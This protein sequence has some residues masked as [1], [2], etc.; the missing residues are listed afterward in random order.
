MA[1]Y[2]W[3]KEAALEYAKKNKINIVGL[4]N[5]KIKDKIKSWLIDNNHN[6]WTCECDHPIQQDDKFCPFCGMDTS[7]DETGG[8]GKFKSEVKEQPTLKAEPEE[9][10][11]EEV[12]EEEIEEEE[13]E[14]VDEEP[15]KT[16]YQKRVEQ[17]KADKKKVEENFDEIRAEAESRTTEIKNVLAKSNEGYWEI[18]FHLHEIVSK[19]GHKTLNYPTFKEYLDKEFG[20]ARR[21]AYN[22]MEISQKVT[23]EMARKVGSIF[24][25]ATACKVKDEK[26]RN[27]LLLDA[28]PKSNKVKPKVNVNNISET[29]TDLRVKIGEIDKPRPAEQKKSKYR[30]FIGAQTKKAPYDKEKKIW[31]LPI[32]KWVGIQIKQYKNGELVGEVIEL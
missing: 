26:Q 5:Q 25:L 23:K 7:E 28:I 1:K 32:D 21:T 12:E 4:S 19:D 17:V 9:E 29:V 18:G 16:N 6:E 14:E 24:V 10:E 22:Y 20:M 2:E 13:I 3:Y 30:R 11:I 8:F 15:K 27:K 31:V